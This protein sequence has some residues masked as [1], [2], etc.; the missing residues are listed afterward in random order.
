MNERAAGA[1]RPIHDV[2]GE[3]LHVG[4][5]VGIGMRDQVDQARPAAPDPQHPVA[6]PERPDRDR[7]NRRVEPRHVA[8]ARQDPNRAL[9]RV[10]ARPP[11]R[12]VLR[13]QLLI[14]LPSPLRG[15]PE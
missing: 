8:A 12:V 13:L 6:L 11:R 3:L 9:A 4:T 15:T 10:H 1:R 2:F 7:P 5:V 14:G